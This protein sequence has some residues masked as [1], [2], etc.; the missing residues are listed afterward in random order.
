M[1]WQARVQEVSFLLSLQSSRLL[2]NL[3]ARECPKTEIFQ[4]SA[5][6]YWQFCSENARNMRVRKPANGV[7]L[8]P[9]FDSVKS[10]AGFVHERHIG[11]IEQAFCDLPLAALADRRVRGEFKPGEATSRDAAQG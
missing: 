10:R 3:G 4:M 8:R 7:A 11:L 1:D 2:N 6:N 5:G 9:E